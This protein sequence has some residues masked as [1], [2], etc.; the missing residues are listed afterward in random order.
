MNH[1]WLPFK[2]VELNA[3]VLV[4]DFIQ[5]HLPT[6]LLLFI[7]LIERYCRSAW[8]VRLGCF[9]LHCGWFDDKAGNKS[10]LFF[11][12]LFFTLQMENTSKHKLKYAPISSPPFKSPASPNLDNS[13][14][15][16]IWV[17]NFCWLS[18]VVWAQ[19]SMMTSWCYSIKVTSSFLSHRRWYTGPHNE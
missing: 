9:Y 13:G 3:L 6:I 8:F 7:S 16:P 18:G 2:W 14:T 11:L 4:L 15:V 10:G 17:A 12:F 1:V 19:L 5:V